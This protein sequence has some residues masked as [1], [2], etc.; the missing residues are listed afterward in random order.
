MEKEHEMYVR[1]HSENEMENG[2]DADSL[3]K[4]VLVNKVNEKEYEFEVWG[5]EDLDFENGLDQ[6]KYE[7]LND[8]IWLSGVV[9]ELDLEDV[10]EVGEKIDD[11]LFQSQLDDLIHGESREKVEELLIDY[12]MTGKEFNQKIPFKNHTFDIKT[13]LIDEEIT[14]MTEAAMKDE[15][16]KKDI[17]DFGSLVEQMGENELH[18]GKLEYLKEPFEKALEY[19]EVYEEELSAAKLAFDALQLESPELFEA[20]EYELELDFVKESGLVTLEYDV[21]RDIKQIELSEITNEPTY[22]PHYD[23][24]GEEKNSKHYDEIPTKTTSYQLNEKNLT[25]TDAE[26]NKE[27]PLAQVLTERQFGRVKNAIESSENINLNLDSVNVEK[28]KDITKDNENEKSFSNDK[29]QEN[30][31]KNK[32]K[33]MEHTR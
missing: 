2:I 15:L 29:S 17:V 9:E 28:I 13:L 20:L 22:V 26:T 4:L 12:N 25:F 6:I 1:S 3:G 27:Y 32:R 11:A 24:N 23:L 33:N 18:V 14:R 10:H 30:A 31:I 8:L 16:T 21:E 19:S 5:K 7:G